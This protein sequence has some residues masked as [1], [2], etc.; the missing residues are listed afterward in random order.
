MAK[1]QPGNTIGKGGR[2]KGTTLPDELIGVKL[3]TQDAVKRK[4]SLYFDK[5]LSELEALANS[6]MT[7]ALDAIVATIL[8][9]AKKYGDYA[10][11]NF[12]FERCIGKVKEE[13]E[14]SVKVELPSVSEA[15]QILDA[16][17][18]LL[19]PG[20]VEVEEL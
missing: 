5:P 13:R 12:L 19:E 20:K 15:K 4:V 16:D 11:L 7:P 1:F 8:V 2:P 18:A 3:L 6:T 9:K 17:Y 14:I 10:R